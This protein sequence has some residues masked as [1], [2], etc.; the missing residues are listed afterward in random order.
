MDDVQR[1]SLVT[2]LTISYILM[3]FMPLVAIIMAYVKRSECQED[4]VLYSHV[5]KQ[6]KI[7]WI[8]FVGYIVSMML[9]VVLI[10]IPML[11]ALIV[12]IIYRVIKGY[13]NLQKNLPV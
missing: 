3:I 13:S 8:G 10:G 4:P 12:W 7:A 9:I 2:W 5:Q 1:K 11:L 6:I